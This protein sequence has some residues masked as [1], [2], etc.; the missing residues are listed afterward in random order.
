M[1]LPAME[2]N[3]E[4]ERDWANE[5]QSIQGSVDG[6]VQAQDHFDRGDQERNQALT[7]PATNRGARVSDHKEGKQLILGPG[8]GRDLRKPRVAND[9]R[10]QQRV[11]KKRNNIG[12]ADVKAA[13][14]PDDE[15]AKRPDHSHRGQVVAPLDR[16]R[17]D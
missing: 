13:L 15:R 1:R 7:T 4:R 17:G 5:K 6:L 3:V 16:K 10:A 11:G 2:P 8:D 12:S 14:A 9:V